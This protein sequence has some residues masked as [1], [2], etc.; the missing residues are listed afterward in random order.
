VSGV[1]RNE[2]RFL[3]RDRSAI[4]YGAVWLKVVER[5]SKEIVGH[6][7]TDRETGGEIELHDCRNGKF[8]TFQ[9]AQKYFSQASA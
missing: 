1:Y 3:V 7:W 2:P 6:Y 9:A 5:P 8:Q 4:H